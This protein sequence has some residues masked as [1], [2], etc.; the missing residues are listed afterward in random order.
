M[1]EEQTEKMFS[2][3]QVASRIGTDAKQLRKFLRDENSGYDAVGQG[4]RY[5]FPESQL[6]A[7]A[8]AFATWNAGKTKRNRSGSTT[9]AGAS[10][11]PVP[12]PRSSKQSLYARTL[13]TD[14]PLDGRDGLPA[15]MANHGLMRDQRGRLVEQPEGA[16]LTADQVM[17]PYA[18]LKAHTEALG[19]DDLDSTDL[20]EFELVED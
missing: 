15:R 8:A 3:K 13:G 16:Q 20:D 17:N 11:T 19:D 7:I 1:S 9:R 14:G 6:P 10:A 18:H 5:D 2:A 4:G 12:R